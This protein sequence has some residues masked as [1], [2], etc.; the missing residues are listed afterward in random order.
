MYSDKEIINLLDWGIEG[1]HY[2][3]TAD[4]TI[5]FPAG[6]DA[7]TSAYAMNAPFIWGNSFLSSV[8]KGD[9]PDLYKQMDEFNKSATKSK[10][11]GFMFNTSNVKNEMTALQNVIDQYRRVLA[12]GTVS[13]DKKVMEFQKKLKDAGIDKVI[14]EKQKQIDEWAKVNNVK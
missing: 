5:D 13:D 6:V 4:G 3:K 9:S 11:L 7:K 8:W 10:A 2:V 1:T 14:A 12:T